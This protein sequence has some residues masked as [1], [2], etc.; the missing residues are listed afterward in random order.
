MELDRLRPLHQE[1]LLEPDPAKKNEILDELLTLIQEHWIH[2]VGLV[3]A[4]E[5][6]TRL[7]LLVDDLDHI[8][9]ARRGRS[10]APVQTS[11]SDFPLKGPGTERGG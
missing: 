5:D 11:P 8:L 7:Q 4:E 6:S 1:F 10:P 3:A 2:F 9:E